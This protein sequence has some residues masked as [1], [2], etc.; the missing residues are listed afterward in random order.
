MQLN[1]NNLIFNFCFYFI[2]RKKGLGNATIENLHKLDRVSKEFHTQKKGIRECNIT[3]SP[4]E[5]EMIWMIS[6]SEKRD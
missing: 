6:Y 2:L 3:L 4:S 1:N 5:E